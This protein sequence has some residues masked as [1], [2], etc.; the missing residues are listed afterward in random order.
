MTHEQ[1]ILKLERDKAERLT[2]VSEVNVDKSDIVMP[3]TTVVLLI[4]G[5]DKNDKKK[6]IR[7]IKSSNEETKGGR[8]VDSSNGTTKCNFHNIKLAD[9]KWII[10]GTS[11]TTATLN[12]LL[13]L[14]GEQK[15]QFMTRTND[16]I[17]FARNVPIKTQMFVNYYFMD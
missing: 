10:Y 17:V 11:Q 4:H 1:I 12:K 5:T 14:D 16:L 13:K 7:S 8:I 6:P 3:N 15:D 9:L 2:N